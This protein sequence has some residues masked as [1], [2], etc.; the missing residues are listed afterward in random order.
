MLIVISHSEFLPGEA[1]IVNELFRLG[2]EVFHIRKYDA[3]AEKIGVFV[4]SVEDTYRDRLVLNHHHDLGKKLGIKRFH[5]SER[6]RFSL[7]LTDYNELNSEYVYSTSVH[8][9]NSFNAL[10][11]QFDYAFLSPV[12]DSIS[13]PTYCAESFDLSKRTNFHTKLIGLGGID[14]TTI[15]EVSTRGFDGAALLGAIWNSDNPIQ[16]FIDTRSATLSI[17]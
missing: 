6:D 1:G 16:S 12:F 3:S 8:D 4:N 5:F 17:N 7:E 9:L 11:P 2:L 13:K 14:H 10:P 15:A